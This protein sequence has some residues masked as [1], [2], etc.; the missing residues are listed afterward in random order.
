MRR[1]SLL[2]CVRA[3]EQEGDAPGK[4]KPSGAPSKKPDDDEKL[5]L[6]GVR[7]ALEDIAG[8]RTST[9]EERELALRLLKVIDG[10]K[11]VTDTATA[12]LL[13]RS[14]GTSYQHDPQSGALRRRRP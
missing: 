5:D 8:D 3:I 12:R 10:D 2:Q 4:K 14:F 9:D 1:P 11:A 13:A 6:D 7:S